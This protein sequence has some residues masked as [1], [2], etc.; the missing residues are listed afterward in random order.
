ME[1]T[2]KTITYEL[3]YLLRL[4]ESESIIE[5][6]MK[7]AGVTVT[8]K[9]PINQ[10]NLAYTIAKQ[11]TALFGFYQMTLP[12]GEA[13]KQIEDALRHNEAVIRSLIVKLP[14]K[15]AV[16]PGKERIMKTDA[17]DKKI[18]PAIGNIDALSNEKLEETLEEILK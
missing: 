3:A 10:I 8:L 18:A 16:A 13:V 5:S 1:T 2:D 17:G 15:K 4:G 14:K 7:N 6:A 9:G 11:D 12:S